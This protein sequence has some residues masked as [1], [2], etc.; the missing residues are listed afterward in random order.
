MLAA[1]RAGTLKALVVA[2]DNPLLLLPDRAQARAALEALDLLLVIDD[3]ATDTVEAATHVLADVPPLGKD[4]STT[5]ADR[6]I[7]RL[8]PALAAAPDARPAWVHL[9]DLVARIVD[10]ATAYADTVEVMNAIATEHSNYVE[11]GAS[12]LLRQTRQP[13][14]GTHAAEAFLSTGALSAS[15]SGLA[16]VAS[17]DLYTDREAASARLAG[18]DP[19]QRGQYLELHPDDA[20]QRSIADGDSVRISANG[21]SQGA[22][23]RLSDEITPGTAFLPLLWEAGAVQALIGPDDALPLVEVS[24]G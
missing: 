4:G 2:K 10:G 11:L 13:S 14:N 19:T 1:A 12:R 17:R 24:K 18:A 23:A 9:Q 3:V 16:L 20:G 21:A 6:Q 15:G 22:T 7:L 5:N 8:R